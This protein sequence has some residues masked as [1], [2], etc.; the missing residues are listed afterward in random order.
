[1]DTGLVTAQA[2]A[3]NR[4]RRRMT[5]GGARRIWLLLAA[6]AAIASACSSGADE[7]SAA[8]PASTSAPTTVAPEQ[9]TTSEAPAPTTDAPVEEEP[10]GTDVDPVFEQGAAVIEQS[11][12]PINPGTH[13]VDAV[14]TPFSVATTGQAVGG[15]PG[16]AIFVLSL[17]HI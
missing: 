5:Y 7:T 6:L 4:W 15:S 9:T 10:D 11:F 12:G 16:G 2:V 13:R 14:G 3:T 8:E 1:M 17:I